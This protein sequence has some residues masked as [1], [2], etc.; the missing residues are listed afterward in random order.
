MRKIKVSKLREVVSALCLKA[1]FELRKD[2]L[3]ALKSSV[4]READARARSML[5]AIIENAAIA[6]TR[7]MA[8]CQDTGMAVVHMDIGQ[9]VVFTGGS[10]KEAVDKGVEDAYKKGYFRKSVVDDPRLRRNT[11]TNTPAILYTDIVDGDRVRISVS[12]KGFGSENKSMVKMFNPTASTEEIKRFVLSVVREA[13]PD[14]CPPLVLGIGMGGTFEKAALLAKKALLR[15][16][17]R[18]NPKRHMAKLETELLKDINS[19]GIGPMGLGG[20][21]TA[22]G[23]NILENP[24]HIAGLP[25]AVNVSCHVTRSAEAVI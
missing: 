13:G 4:K 8:I 16:I 7:K 20:R 22:L 19:L 6:R 1:N 2:V 25:V 5:R 9:D 3:C 15:P 21:T 17:H 14:A 23:V 18:K 12:S 10:L 11:G 24:T